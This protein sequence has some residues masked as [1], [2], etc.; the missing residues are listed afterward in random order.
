MNFKTTVEFSTND[1]HETSSSVINRLV[2]Q[3]SYS[4]VSLDVNGSKFTINPVSLDVNGSKFTINPVTF[5]VNG[6]NFTIT[7]ACSDNYTKS[8]SFSAGVVGESFIGGL[9][10]GIITLC[11]IATTII[12]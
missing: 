1:G 3:A 7:E 12:V 9:L 5:D 2:N 8:L 4:A 10:T 6:S 11:I